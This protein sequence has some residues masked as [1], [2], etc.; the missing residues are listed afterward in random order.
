MLRRQVSFG[1]QLWLVSLGVTVTV[2][3]TVTSRFTFFFLFIK[4]FFIPCIV[5]YGRKGARPP[6]CVG[7]K[8]GGEEWGGTHKCGGLGTGER[9]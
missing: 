5:L 8:G 1:D 9:N 2:T 7:W 6:R 3:V 4:A